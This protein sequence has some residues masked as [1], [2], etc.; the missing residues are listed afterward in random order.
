LRA[1]EVGARALFEQAGAGN[2]GDPVARLYV[3]ELADPRWGGVF[4]L[5]S[6]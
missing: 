1:G 6:K 3:Q 2:V 4:T 5:E